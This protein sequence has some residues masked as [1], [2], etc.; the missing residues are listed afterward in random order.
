MVTAG[1]ELQRYL[2]DAMQVQVAVKR[3]AQLGDWRNRQQVI[4]AAARDK[5]PGCGDDTESRERLSDRGLR[6]RDRRVRLR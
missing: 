6:Q 2:K 3:P 5:M 1:E 4:V